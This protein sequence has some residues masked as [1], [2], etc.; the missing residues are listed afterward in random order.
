[1]QTAL[2]IDT[3]DRGASFSECRK[4]RYALW[5]IWD[6]QKP[7]VMFIG[8]N[9]STAN[10]NENDPTIKSVE[11]IAKHNGYGGFYMMNCF[12]FVN[13]DPKQLYD[14]S[15][16]VENEKWLKKIAAISKDIV[17][18]WG[19]FQVVKKL[20]V[21]YILGQW[22]PDAK[23]LHINKTGSPIH[24]LYCKTNTVFVKWSTGS[25]CC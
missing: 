2:P 12:S 13:T 21:D 11:R 25:R 6:K 20:G 19:D 3:V 10:E 8:L 14:C 15:Q 9:P 23:C 22:F 18:A 5:R 24:P 4:Y 17:F 16:S 7:L 1:M